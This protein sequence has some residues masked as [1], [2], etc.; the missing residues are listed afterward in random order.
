VNTAGSTA[1]KNKHQVTLYFVRRAAAGANKW[2]MKVAVPKAEVNTC[3]SP[4][5]GDL[6]VLDSIDF[7]TAPAV[8]GCGDGIT[9][10]GEQCDTGRPSANYQIMDCGARYIPNFGA[11]TCSASC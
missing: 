10:T 8:P 5:T 7:T 9:G 11:I 2:T 3:P 1:N 4:G 6:C